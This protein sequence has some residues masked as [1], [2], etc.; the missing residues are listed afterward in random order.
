MKRE[1]SSFDIYVIVSELKD[2]KGS[3]IDKIY[4]LT[5]SELLIKLKIIERQIKKKSF[6][7]EM[8]NF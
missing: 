5:R 8:V 7:L 2:I 4:Q 3:Y 6:L 1:L